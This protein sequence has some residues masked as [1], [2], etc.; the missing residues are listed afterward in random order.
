MSGVIPGPRNDR[1][2]FPRGKALRAQ[3]VWMN[4]WTTNTS[5]PR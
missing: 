1:S 5:L 2:Q 3:Q 4:D